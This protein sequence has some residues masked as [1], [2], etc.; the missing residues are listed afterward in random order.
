VSGNWHVYSG[1][2]LRYNDTYRSDWRFLHYHPTNVSNRP[3]WTIVMP[4]N[5]TTMSG[6]S[7]FLFTSGFTVNGL[8]ILTTFSRINVQING[9]AI[10]QVMSAAN[11]AGWANGEDRLVTVTADGGAASQTL[12]VW[13]DNTL[14]GQDIGWTGTGANVDSDDPVEF[15]NWKAS[16]PAAGKCMPPFVADYV[17][18][19][20][21]LTVVKDYF[22]DA[23]GYTP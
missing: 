4:V 7:Q 22:Y 20:E 10:A 17:L 5:V 23:M 8:R 2:Y 14:A 19:T 12:S 18:S 21:E 1:D 15:M 11:P 16:F 13:V 9:G 6:I 3:S